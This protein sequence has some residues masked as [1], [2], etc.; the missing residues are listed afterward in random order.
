[1]SDESTERQRRVLGLLLSL[2]EDNRTKAV[3]DWQALTPT[4]GDDAR[5]LLNAALKVLLAVT[6][7]PRLGGRMEYIT[8]MLQTYVRMEAAGR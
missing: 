7:D 5:A 2:L 4:D 8:K 1:M 3:R 6:A